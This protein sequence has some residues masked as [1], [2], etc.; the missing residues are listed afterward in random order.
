[1]DSLRVAH[2]TLVDFVREP[3]QPEE[4]EQN[5]LG[6]LRAFPNLFSS[7]A[8]INGQLGSLGFYGESEHYLKE[9]SQK[10]QAITAQDVQDAVRRHIQPDRLTI[11]VASRDLDQQALNK[12][13]EENLKSNDSSP[14]VSV[15]P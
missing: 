15:S 13:I 2:Q 7:N 1:M 12:I 4:L 10:L 6:M 3:I 9:Y 5:K 8:V 11:I 14:Q